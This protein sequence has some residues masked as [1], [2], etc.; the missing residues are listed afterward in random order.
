VT[1]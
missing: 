1:D